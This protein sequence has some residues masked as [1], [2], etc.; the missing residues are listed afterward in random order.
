MTEVSG[1]LTGYAFRLAIVAAM[2]GFLFGFDISIISGALIFLE[3]E[4]H[5]TAAQ[6]G[7]AVSSAAIGCVAGPLVSVA[8]SDRIGR[9]K[10]LSVAALL[11]GTSALGTALAGSMPAL[12]AFRLLGGV[13]VGL[14]SV[15]S[16]MYIAEMAPAR[17]R[18]RLVSVNQLAIVTGLF[19]A[20][21]VSYGLSFGGHWRWMFASVILPA[22][23]WLRGLSLLPESPRWLA[24]KGLVPEALKLLEKSEG[25]EGSVRA[26][27][28]I[29]DSISEEQGGWN[30]V[31]Q[32]GMRRALLV[33]VVLAILQQMTGVSIL[34]V[35]APTLFQSAGFHAASDAIWQAIPLNLWNI[36]CTA[37]AFWLV[38]RLGRRPLLLAGSAIMAV[39]LFWM[40]LCFQ[41]G[42]S[43]Y[44]VVLVMFLCVG[45][46]V[47]SLAPLAWLIMSEIFPTRIRGKAMSV[48]GV[49]LWLAFFLGSQFFP[50][51]SAAFENRYGSPAG[52]FWLFSGVCL[53]SFLFC[54]RLVPETK[55]RSLEEIAASWKQGGALPSGNSQ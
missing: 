51:L 19:L 37:L 7:F 5:L 11:L 39:G 33:A 31:F 28:D 3:S 21:V 13:G 53:F 32:P 20:I 41:F 48:A 52:V 47:S 49:A 1:G 2:G 30:E 12:Y 17:L 46:F 23:L 45:A 38:D 15:V 27:K 10:T 24:A 36:L 43:G 50:T 4:F 55:G 6:K 16:P 9:K 26:L 25:K 18:G 40:G 35:Y 54:W 44:S 34:L 22:L 29:Q 42:W 8:L 14:A